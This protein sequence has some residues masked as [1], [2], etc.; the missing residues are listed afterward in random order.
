ML[1]RSTL[2]VPYE[3]VPVARGMMWGG[4]A[5]LLMTFLREKDISAQTPPTVPL[6]TVTVARTTVFLLVTLGAWQVFADDD[7][8]VAPPEDV[9]IY[10][11][12]IPVDEEGEV[13]GDF[14]HVPKPLY[15]SLHRPASVKIKIGRAH[16]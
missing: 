6:S 8:N 1:F 3:L 5:G 2:L 12:V 13:V 7:V 14:V 4:L 15:N 10:R 9:I 11:V 16:V